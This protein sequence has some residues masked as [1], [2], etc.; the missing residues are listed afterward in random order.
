MDEEEARRRFHESAVARLA[1]VRPDGAPHIVPIVFAVDGDDLYTAVD[2]K[3]KGGGRLQ[4]LA[5]LRREPRCAVL[6]DRYDDDWSQLWWARADGE[7]T[8]IDEPPGDHPGLRALVDRYPQY[9]S[10][11]P[12]GPLIAI[13]VSRWSGWSGR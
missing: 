6:I 12:D 13:R 4:R 1:T 9:R 5:N 3:P 10:D 11:A 2:Q 8:V 7:A